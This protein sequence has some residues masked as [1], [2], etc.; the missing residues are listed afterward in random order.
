M[1]QTQASDHL[2]RALPGVGVFGYLIG[3]AT[4]A[5]VTAFGVVTLVFLL[6][7]LIPG[8]PVEVML[9][10][11]AQ[12]ADL[13]ALR[14]SLGLDQPLARQYG[15]YLA[16]LAVGDLGESL[17]HGRPVAQLLGE[18]IGPTAELAVAALLI[19]VGIA[20]PLGIAAALRRGRA[21]DLAASSL[22]LAGV[23]I[24]NFWLGPMLML[25]F[26]LWLGWTPISGRDAP[27]GL[28]LPAVTLG[29]GLAAILARMLRASLL[30]VLG[31]DYVRSARARGLSPSRVLVRHALRNAWMPFVTVLGLQLGV[32]LGGAVIV[33][34][35]FGW[36]GLG[37]LMIESIQRR[38]YP[39]VQGAVL[40]IALSYVAVNALTDLAYG[41]LDPRV[42]QR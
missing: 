21:V 40:L 11:S 33:E 25:V 3:R 41:W 36:P 6:L 19:A 10:E 23:S 27:G 38:D 26:G 32:L 28:I 15:R 17:S 16:G 5:L 4:Q 7:H 30:E 2:L 12:P 9:G 24:P 39:V 8:D 14:A 42:R 31:E 34:V 29:T 35:V 20:I 18:R 22:S 1:V 37:S 13:E